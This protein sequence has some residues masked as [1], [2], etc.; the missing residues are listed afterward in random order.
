[1]AGMTALRAMFAA[2]STPQRTSW[3]MTPPRRRRGPRLSPPPC[4]A[5]TPP[6]LA[7]APPEVALLDHRSPSDLRGPADRQGRVRREG[8]GLRGRPRHDGHLHI[9]LAGGPGG[10]AGRARERGAGRR[11]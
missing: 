10:V 7:P 6:T 9:P 5:R 1:M 3:P 11:H 2:P 8:G 4:P